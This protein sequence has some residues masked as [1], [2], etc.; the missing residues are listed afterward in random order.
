MSPTCGSHLSGGEREHRAT[1]R[2]KVKWAMPAGPVG[3][4]GPFLFSPFFFF[5]FILFCFVFSFISFAI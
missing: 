2:E 5:L 4:L 1:V 3:C